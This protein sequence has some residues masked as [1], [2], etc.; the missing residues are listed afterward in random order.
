[1][2]GLRIG[3]AVKECGHSFAIVNPFSGNL[4]GVFFPL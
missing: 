4:Y 2:K 3:A 1:M